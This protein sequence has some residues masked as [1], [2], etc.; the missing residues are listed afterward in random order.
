LSRFTP[1][2]LATLVDEVPTGEGWM[3]EVKYDGYRLQAI[4]ARGRCRLYTRSGL[5][6]TDKFEPIARACAQLPVST[7]TLDGE[8]VVRTASG[9]TSFQQL[10]QELDAGRS[11]QLGYVVFDVL[12]MAGV[13]W[14]THPLAD[15]RRALHALLGRRRGT[16]RISEVLKG[17]ASKLLQAS[18]RAGHEGVISKRLTAP[19]RSGRG[20]D[21]VKVKCGHRQ[22]FVVLGYTQPSG[23]REGLG[24]L[25]LGVRDGVAWRYAGRVGSGFDDR[26]LRTL[27]AKLQRMTRQRS[28]LSS[29]PAGLPSGVRWVRP[30]V[31]VEVS[32]TEWTA[33]GHL[34][35]PVFQGVRTDKPASEIRR[36]RAVRAPASRKERQ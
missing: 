15:R 29:I 8:A 23:S 33:A 19:Y 28:A 9:I 1:P 22:E 2:A 21:W 11:L 30:E 34:R 17:P 6:W 13:R 32:F 12:S 25:L 14:A 36:E 4:I 35:H 10:Q 24:A 26:T 5:D 16:I 3:H 18:C 7:A 31:V 27:H 20:T